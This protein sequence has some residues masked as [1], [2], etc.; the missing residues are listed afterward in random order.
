MSNTFIAAFQTALA[1]FLSL[2]FWCPL[3]SERECAAPVNYNRYLNE[4]NLNAGGKKRKELE[5]LITGCARSGTLYITKVLR[6]NGLAVRHEIHQGSDYGI[7]SWCMAVDSN[8]AAYGP[9]SNRYNFKHIFHQVRHPLKAIAS[10]MT[11]GKRS[12]EFICKQVP[13]IPMDDPIL[14]RSAKYWF[15]WNLHAES[16]AELTYQ[17]ERVAEVLPEM[18]KRSW[19]PP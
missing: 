14:V 17:I 18:S 3:Y 6:L 11:E 13:H 4:W 12:W 10:Q 16:K 5:L 7:V 19:N 8:K 2:S 9:P 15:Y 1:C